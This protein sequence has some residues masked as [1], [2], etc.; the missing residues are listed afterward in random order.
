MR[1][2]LFDED[3]MFR[4]IAEDALVRDGHEV[5]GVA[6]SALHC[7]DLVETSKPDVLLVDLSSGS[8]TDFD[9]VASA[10]DC[11]T[12]VIIFS[13]LVDDVFLSRYDPRP[14]FVAKPDYAELER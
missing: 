13:F 12:S 3:D 10:N 5:V 6:D 4:A 14:I 7:V 8:S 1:F 2:V 11:D 9:V